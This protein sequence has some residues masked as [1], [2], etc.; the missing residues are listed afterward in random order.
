MAMRALIHRGLCELNKVGLDGFLADLD[1][2]IPRGRGRF[3]A[4]FGEKKE[5]THKTKRSVIDDEE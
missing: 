5:E 4:L 3:A 1:V 2:T